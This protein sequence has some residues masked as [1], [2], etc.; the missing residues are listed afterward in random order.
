V[1][2]DEHEVHRLGSEDDETDLS[3]EAASSDHWPYP[4]PREEWGLWELRLCPPPRRRAESSSYR[5]ARPNQFYP[6]YIDP[7]ARE[8]VA[9]GDS[10]PRDADPI[11]KPKKGPDSRVAYRQGRGSPVL[12]DGQ[13]S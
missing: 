8:V 10:L 13:G 9:V 7:A 1:T 4:F 6:I 3:V 12:A 5:S 2:I 11:A